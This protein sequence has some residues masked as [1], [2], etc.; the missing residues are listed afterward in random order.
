MN[1]NLSHD[2]MVECMQHSSSFRTLVA[3]MLQDNAPDHK[4]IKSDIDAMMTQNRSNIIAAIK[5]LRIA[6]PDRQIEV[7]SNPAANPNRI[8]ISLSSAKK[9]VEYYIP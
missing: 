9:F 3:D 1:F 5:A 6:Y 2:M 8:V 7:Y 4:R